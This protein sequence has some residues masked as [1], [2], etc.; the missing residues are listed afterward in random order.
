M[1]HLILHGQKIPI[2]FKSLVHIYKRICKML[3]CRTISV[4]H[5]NFP[6]TGHLRHIYVWIES[7]HDIV[8]RV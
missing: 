3:I 1:R 5:F 7:A 4:D 6:G 8:C 2:S